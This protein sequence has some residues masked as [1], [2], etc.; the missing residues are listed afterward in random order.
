MSFMTYFFAIAKDIVLFKIYF[1][2]LVF[3]KQ[4]AVVLR[5]EIVVY[6][7]NY[8]NASMLWFYFY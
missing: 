7:S 4:N 5:F 8:Q 1:R 6:F 3:P 2:S